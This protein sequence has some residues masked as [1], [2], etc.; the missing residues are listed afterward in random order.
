VPKMSFKPFALVIAALSPCLGTAA[1]APV[2]SSLASVPAGVATPVTFTATISDATVIAGSVNLLRIDS[3]GR[4]TIV[5]TMHDDGVNGDSAAGD[6]VY[7]FLLNVFEQNSG[8]VNYRVSAAF[9][10]SLLREQSGLIPLTISGVSTSISIST[11]GDSAYLNISPTT[12]SGTVGDPAA[13]VTVNGIAAQVSGNA[14]TASVPLQEGL[15]TL[16]AVAQNS[17][18]TV[19]TASKT[20]TLDT[21]PPH[22][23]IDTPL[24]NAVTT[25][26]TINV[27]GIV[28]DIV[29][30]TV[31]NLQA[32]VTVNG[33]AAQVANRTYSAVNVPLS[34]G[35]N[36]IQATGRDRAGNFGTASV[37]VVRQPA[38]QPG[39]TIVSGNNL[40]GTIGTLLSAPLV[41]Q[42]LD[43]S[44]HPI[45]GTP[46]V[47]AVTGGNGTVSATATAGIS[48]I[49]VNTNGQGQAQV[50]FTLGSRAGSGNNVVTASSA[51]IASTAIFTETA[52]SNAVSAIVVDSGNNQSGV[53]GQALP[54]PFI[55]ITT[56]AGHNRLGNV[57]VTFTVTQ[58]GGNFGGPAAITTTS[59]SDGRAEAILTLGAAAGPNVVTA[60]FAGDT[61]LPATFTANGR[62]PGPPANTTI[63]GVVLD[64][65]NNPIAGVTM[66]LYQTNSGSNN[67]VPQQVGT[68]VQTNAQGLFQIAPAPVGVFKLM[69][70]GTTAIGG[71]TFPTLEYDLVTVAGQNNTVG[72]P[73]YLPQISSA[74][75][76]CVSATTGGTLTVPQAPGFALTIAAGSATFPGGTQ[77]GCVS[78]TPVNPDK[79]PM[80][81]GFGQQPRFIVTIQPVGTTFNPPAAITIPNV[82]GLAPRTVTEMYSYDHDLATFTAIGTGTVSADGSVIASDPG[83]GVLKAGWH[84]GGDPNTTGGAETV[85][86]SVSKTTVTLAVGGTFNVTAIG[87]PIPIGNP[88]YSWASADS[89]IAS[90]AYA[91]GND[92][93][94]SPN[95]ATFTGMAAGQT[96][97][98]VTYK[99][100]SGASATAQVTVKVVQVDSIQVS[101][102]STKDAVTAA[103][104]AAGTFTTVNKSTDYVPPIDDLLVIAKNAADLSTT[105][106]NPQPAGAAGDLKWQIDKN[107]GDIVVS[108]VPPL[109][110]LT[111]ATTTVA[112]N[113]PGNFRLIVYV[114]TN[115]N[116]HWDAGEELRV[117]RMSIFRITP[118]AGG[119]LRTPGAITS[120]LNGAADIR[121][122]AGSA[123]TPAMQLQNDYLLEGGSGDGQLGIGKM[124]LGNIGNLLNDTYQVNY[125]VPNPA[126]PAPGNVAGTVN[127][128]PGGTPPMVDS[129]HVTPRGATASGGANPFRGNSLATNQGAGPGGSGAI[130]HVT[131]LDAPQFDIDQFTHPVTGNP[132]ASNQG[133]NAFRE[134][135]VVFSTDFPRN[136]MALG[137]GDWTVTITGTNN[138]GA[139]QDGGSTITSPTAW[140]TAGY[141]LT[142]DTAG[143][144]VLGLSFVTEASETHTP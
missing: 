96:T 83:V 15:N 21:T 8:T 72:S 43:G 45:T 106:V 66:R 138:A 40:I 64:N 144:Q 129:V 6:Q 107:P 92:S 29:V 137:T 59:D 91:T 73:I 54:L 112:P 62:I 115:S 75:Q 10:G 114:D 143:V 128:T 94:S 113:N 58:G 61:G 77:S 46:V 120:A 99:C 78:V 51:G 11:P 22:V 49:A 127:E 31:N 97:I 88:A 42:L 108:G 39:I 136:Y 68:P 76:L 89:T 82:D 90:V 18:N 80:V 48:S 12:V 141:P 134:W 84:C 101:V 104:P 26:S 116:G 69:A 125:P 50:Y 5:G 2:G 7:S 57:T 1:I 135:A 132:W 47:F 70:D 25:A 60:D 103:R 20:A 87:G 63:S 142:G 119:F 3:A 118:Q 100:Q 23:S 123:D 14:F 85:A 36:T 124:Q 27:T 9:P 44:G 52:N 34:L 53:V 19:S 122:S 38:T 109:S 133:V 17:N 35:S 79:I 95:T 105:A 93:Q 13:T 126:P 139:W 24:D 98:T 81:P 33:I 37:T 102:L 110:S 71:G 56:D 16:T 32:T 4:A 74:S 55:V 30:G 86:V 41:V 28:N 130:I 121:I 67:N 140:T 65:S 111:G 131:S 117:L